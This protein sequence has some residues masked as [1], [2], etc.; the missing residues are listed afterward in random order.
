MLLILHRDF[1]RRGLR[2]EEKDAFFT[3]IPVC[4]IFDE[5]N[6]GYDCHFRNGKCE[7][8][9]NAKCVGLTFQ[10]DELYLLPLCENVNFV[11]DVNENVSS[12]VNANKKEK[13]T[14]DASLKLWH[15]VYAIFQGEE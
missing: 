14:H 5:D 13:R 9:F 6:D 4:M 2:K 11:C 12:P 10:Q 3:G 8:W 7:V 15:V 1:V